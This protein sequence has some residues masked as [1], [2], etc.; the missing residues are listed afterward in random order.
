MW[1]WFLPFLYAAVAA[2]DS[3]LLDF[4]M[5]FLAVSEEQKANAKPLECGCLGSTAA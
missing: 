1:L 5:P 3:L 4:I 2:Q